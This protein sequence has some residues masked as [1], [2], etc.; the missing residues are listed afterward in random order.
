LVPKKE[1]FEK[2]LGTILE[3]R[4]RLVPSGGGYPASVG[5]GA[6]WTILVVAVREL[7]VDERRIPPVA[8][9]E[10]VVPSALAGGLDRAVLPSAACAE[11]PPR[12][13]IPSGRRGGEPADLP[14]RPRGLIVAGGSCRQ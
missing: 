3:S 9:F 10:R 13:A 12:A 4:R 6:S 14:R 5:A 1:N 7:F 8:W 11:W 2:A